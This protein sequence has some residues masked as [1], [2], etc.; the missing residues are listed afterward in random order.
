MKTILTTFLFVL[1]SISLFGQL[2]SSIDFVIGVD[3]SFRTLSVT[4][5]SEF[6]MFAVESRADD[7]R[8]VNWSIGINYRRPL[9]EKIY[10]KLG[11]KL[12]TIGF[13]TGLQSDLRWPSEYNSQGVWTPDP[14]LP[15]EVFF[16]NDLWFL[17]APFAVGFE[18]AKKRISFF[19]ELGLTPNFIV[20]ERSVQVTNLGTSSEIRRTLGQIKPQ[21]VATTAFGLV[22]KMKENIS[23][24]I[25]PTFR[26]HLTKLVDGLI[27]EHRYSYG[28][29][30]GF[31]KNL[32]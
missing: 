18:H 2:R 31:R 28:V 12:T 22:Y 9:S 14:S 10:L 6:S 24:Y 17:G 29:E 5:G 25:Q 20:A 7:K 23:I 21:L 27:N 15:R 19:Y 32:N 13:I 26:Y 4:D 16:K 3:H 30:L 1:L 8:R 11:A